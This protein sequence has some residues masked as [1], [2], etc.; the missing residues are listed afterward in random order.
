[1]VEILLCLLVPPQADCPIA[2]G[3]ELA[4]DEASHV[5]DEVRLPL[6]R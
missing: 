4:V 6:R 5:P 1:M 3:V 2:E